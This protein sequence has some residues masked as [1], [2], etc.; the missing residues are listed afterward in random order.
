MRDIIDVSQLNCFAKSILAA[1]DR[2][3][4]LIVCGEIT[5]FKKQY[6]SGHC[7]F[8]L[9]DENS[10]VKCVMFSRRARLLDFAP[11]DGMMVLD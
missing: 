11:E 5:N 1:D 2:M 10:T 7:Y 3:N 9:R 6:S 8:T 4:D